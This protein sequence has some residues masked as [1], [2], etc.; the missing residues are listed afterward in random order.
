VNARA[1]VQVEGQPEVIPHRPRPLVN[2]NRE[3]PEPSVL[4]QALSKARAGSVFHGCGDQ[5]LDPLLC[6]GAC[7]GDLLITPAARN[8][9]ANLLM[10]QKLKDG[11]AMVA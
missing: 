9:K 10:N 4:R 6:G 5:L 3:K 11:K 8:I 2:R 7:H 1:V